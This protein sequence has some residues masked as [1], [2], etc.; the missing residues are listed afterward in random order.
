M[1]VPDIFHTQKS[2]T[3]LF[4]GIPAIL[5]KQTFQINLPKNKAFISLY[6]FAFIPC[7]LFLLM[8]KYLHDFLKLLKHLDYLAES[9]RTVLYKQ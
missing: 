6:E 3:A 4:S 8:L 1:A 2:G 7:I 5:S 9:C